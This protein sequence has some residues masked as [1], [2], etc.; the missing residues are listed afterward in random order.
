MTKEQIKI[1]ISETAPRLPYFP[2]CIVNGDI[3]G[4]I[5]ELDA[6][7][8]YAS[9]YVY[10]FYDRELIDAFDL[11]SNEVML[12]LREMD[13]MDEEEHKVYND[14]LEDLRCNPDER[15]AENLLK[16]LLS[17]GFDIHD[18]IVNNEAFSELY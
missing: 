14:L 3:K 7:P 2:K 17:K 16:W 4:Y 1:F 9:A 12:V 6:D 15:T 11:S 10:S 5:V 13:S 18:R 8:T